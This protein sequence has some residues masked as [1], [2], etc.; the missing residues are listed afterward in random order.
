MINNK[1][2]F[3]HLTFKDRQVIHHMRF[4]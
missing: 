4:V 3:K 2:E 1:K